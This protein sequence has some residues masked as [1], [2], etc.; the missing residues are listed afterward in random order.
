MRDLNSSNSIA[1]LYIG[2]L[3]ILL[4]LI[5][6]LI[7]LSYSSC[8]FLLLLNIISMAN[9]CDPLEIITLVKE[10]WR[11]KVRVVRLWSLLSFNNS[12]SIN[13]LEMVVMDEFISFPIL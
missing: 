5:L 8:I 3:S 6:K 10:C 12:D 9:R 1:P 4:S 7:L 13:N 11:I 2:S